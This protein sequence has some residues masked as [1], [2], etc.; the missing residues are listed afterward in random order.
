M[1]DAACGMEKCSVNGDFALQN[2]QKIYRRISLFVFF[3]H[4][5]IRISVVE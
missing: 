1:T 3:W 4:C 2:K 5:A